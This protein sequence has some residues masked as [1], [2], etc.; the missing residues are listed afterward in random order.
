MS[1]SERYISFLSH[2][3]SLSIYI[4]KVFTFRLVALSLSNIVF[5]TTEINVKHLCTLRVMDN[6]Q[7]RK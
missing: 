2:I 4:H 1:T 6:L 5:F 7:D 3:S